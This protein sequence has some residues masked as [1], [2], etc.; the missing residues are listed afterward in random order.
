[1]TSAVA[2]WRVLAGSAL[3]SNHVA[4]G[5]PNQ[6]AIGWRASEDGGAAVL[7][8]ADGHGGA[9]YVRSA[10]GAALAVEIA[11]AIGSPFLDRH[12]DATPENFEQALRSEM[13]PAVVDK[14]QSDVRARSE[15]DPVEGESDPLVAYGSTLLCAFVTERTTAI[16]QL[17]DGDAVVVDPAGEAFRPVPED[18]RL[19]GNAT[20]SL[21]R[22]DAVDDVRVIAVPTDPSSPALLWLSTDG[23][24]NSFA[25]DR[26]FLSVGADILRAISNDGI[27]QVDDQLEAWLE[28]SASVGGDDASLVAV[29]RV[30]SHGR[31]PFPAPAPVVEPP[32]TPPT[33]AT[34]VH[35]FAPPSSAPL[36]PPPVRGAAPPTAP[37]AAD[38]PW[39][40]PA[41][42]A[43][44][45]L[46][47]AALV[48]GAFA[49]TSLGNGQSSTTQPANQSDPTSPSVADTSVT[50][51]PFQ[52]ENPSDG[53]SAA[54]R[55]VLAWNGG[56]VAVDAQG[57][58]ATRRK[59]GGLQPQ[60]TASTASANIA[61]GPGG[62]VI[63]NANGETREFRFPAA[64]VGIV[65]D[66]AFA[67]GQGG[68]TVLVIEL[69]WF[70]EKQIPVTG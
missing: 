61:I 6:D 67:L 20:T 68:N 66:R 42:V 25:D 60:R 43:G 51:D 1:M 58:T 48:G 36:P 18:P 15:H 40:I 59:V 44:V 56:S 64:S 2:Q 33:E 21:C 69:P 10:E 45:I 34:P 37:S 12:R 57:T 17:G 11:L 22:A 27:D 3:G 4:S 70:I 49:I 30:D 39:L 55:I 16:L 65:P 19:F 9:R 63:V 8:V 32:S 31:L 7:A 50:L 41:V 47:L 53:T 14:W 54:D 35:A 29:V 24:A 13:A 46:A 23:Y 28:E 5:L 38:R 62:T 52:P 26:G